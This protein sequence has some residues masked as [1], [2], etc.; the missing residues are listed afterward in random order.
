MPQT[1]ARWILALGTISVCIHVSGDTLPQPAYQFLENHCLD[2]HDSSEQKGDLNLENLGFDLTDQHVMETWIKVHDR[3]RNGEMPPKKKRR[4]E[5][6]DLSNFINT[7]A[8][9]MIRADRQRIANT[10]RSE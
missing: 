6:E 10:A 4:P 8:Q 1:I 5:T 2:C 7:L 9:P 3:A